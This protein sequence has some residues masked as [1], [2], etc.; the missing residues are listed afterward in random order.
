MTKEELIK[1]LNAHTHSIF[2]TFDKVSSLKN[3][4]HCGQDIIIAVGV[5]VNTMVKYF[6]ELIEQL[7]QKE[8]VRNRISNIEELDEE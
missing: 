3:F 2:A 4:N 7:D 5:T 6:I 8:I 1:K